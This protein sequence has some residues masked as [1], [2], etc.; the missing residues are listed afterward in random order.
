[1][2][3]DSM[4]F[5]SWMRSAFLAMAFGTMLH[6]QPAAEPAIPYNDL[7]R[8]HAVEGV[9]LC[10]RRRLIDGGLLLQAVRN[11][12]A[13][14]NEQALRRPSRADRREARRIAGL[15]PTEMRTEVRQHW[16]YA[17]EHDIQFEE[18]ADQ[19]PVAALLM[20]EVMAETLQAMTWHADQMLQALLADDSFQLLPPLQKSDAAPRVAAEAETAR[21]N[22][23]EAT[24]AIEAVWN[25]LGIS[26]LRLVQ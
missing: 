15:N 8:C 19:Q 11:R 13:A 12:A 4:S 14:L 17:W 1:M 24:A 20:L 22:L 23:R 3:M 7:V 10:Q 25:R 21:Q 9:W 5:M 2:S 26:P 18:F 6:G 16:A